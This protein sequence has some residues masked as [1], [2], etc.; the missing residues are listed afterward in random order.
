MRRV[1][2]YGCDPSWFPVPMVLVISAKDWIG[3]SCAENIPKIQMTT[4]IKSKRRSE[5]KLYYVCLFFKKQIKKF[6]HTFLR[7]ASPTKHHILYF[8][9][10]YYAFLCGL[11]H[12]AILFFMQTTHNVRCIF[13][14]PHIAPEKKRSY[15]FFTH[16]LAKPSTPPGHFFL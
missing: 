15:I 12:L 1:R 7:R 9:T 4:I 6:E 5:L 3:Y 13:P 10:V 8:S 2:T 14:P 11:S 16:L